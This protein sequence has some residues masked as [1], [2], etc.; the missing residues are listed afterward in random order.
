MDTQTEKKRY[1]KYLKKIN[2]KLK[3]F[4]TPETRVNDA[5]DFLKK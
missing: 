1:E 5:R 2:G 3:H 4:K